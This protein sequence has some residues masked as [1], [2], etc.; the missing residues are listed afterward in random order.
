MAMKTAGMAALVLVLAGCS[1]GLTGSERGAQEAVMKNVS[2]DFV[3][4]ARDYE[5]VVARSFTVGAGGEWAET[6]GAACTAEAGRFRTQFATPAVVVMPD[7]GPDAPAITA[8]CTLGQLSGQDIVPPDFNWR[9]EGRPPPAK[10]VSYGRGWW[11]GFKKSGPLVYRD[12]AV[13]MR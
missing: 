13:G 11:F 10:R 2:G 5:N 8:T 7:L 4:P 6:P 12:I 1:S 9:E 3:P